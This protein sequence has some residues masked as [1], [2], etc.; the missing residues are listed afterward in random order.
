[1]NLA[2]FLLI[3]ACLF[4]GQVIVNFFHLPLPP[5]I[6]GLMLLFFLLQWQIVPLQI[7]QPISSVLLGYLAFLVVPATISVMLYLDVIWQDWFALTV[8]TTLSTLLVLICVSLS[9]KFV[10]AMIKRDGVNDG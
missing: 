3:F 4:V 1:M 6:I 8:G 10:L 5:S 7:I 9:H 2:G